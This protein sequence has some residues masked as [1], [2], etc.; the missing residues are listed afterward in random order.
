MAQQGRDTHSVF[1]RNQA[2][3]DGGAIAVYLYGH[4]ATLNL[5]NTV[6]TYSTAGTG[7]GGIYVNTNFGPSDA[8]GT[9]TL[10]STEIVGNRAPEGLGG[11]LLVEH[12][13]ANSSLN[14]N[15]QSTLFAQNES[16]GGGAVALKN[17]LFQTPY[18]LRVTGVEF[19][20]NRRLPD[21]DGLR[22]DGGALHITG[23]A[24]ASVSGD[25]CRECRTADLY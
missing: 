11:G 16:V 21:A 15:L 7:G 13:S 23:M 12:S 25:F 5:T 14:I 6:V 10:R 9:I 4:R 2:V 20:N 1:T 3:F 19:L 22:G 18:T 8:P 17:G 24:T